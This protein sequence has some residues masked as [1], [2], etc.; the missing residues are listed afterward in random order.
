MRATVT[1]S[2]DL[3]DLAE[4]AQLASAAVAMLGLRAGELL[5]VIER[6]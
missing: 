2:L 1:R 3:R 6:S 5:F 4:E